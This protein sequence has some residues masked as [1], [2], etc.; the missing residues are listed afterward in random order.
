MSAALI[1]PNVGTV[2]LREDGSATFT[3]RNRQQFEIAAEVV[4]ALVTLSK[5]REAA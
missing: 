2:V 1:L 5:Q 4:A 3:D